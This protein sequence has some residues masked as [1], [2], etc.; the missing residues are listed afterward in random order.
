LCGLFIKD[1][2]SS[3]WILNSWQGFAFLL[4]AK[5][6]NDKNSFLVDETTVS[7]RF[8]LVAKNISRTKNGWFSEIN[9]GS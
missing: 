7:R 1:I 2:I 9:I 5:Q 4:K 3:K 6:S 8:D